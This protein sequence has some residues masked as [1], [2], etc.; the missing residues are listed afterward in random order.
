MNY[1]LIYFIF[2][3]EIY[4]FIETCKININESFELALIYGNI[5]NLFFYFLIIFL[6]VIYMLLKIFNKNM[7][8]DIINKILVLPLAF[9][10]LFVLF[11]LF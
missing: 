11:N 8:L 3:Y 9:L 7:K 4:Y 6:H 2:F 1:A 10:I 5:I